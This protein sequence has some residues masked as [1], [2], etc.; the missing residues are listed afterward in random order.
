[1]IILPL[2]RLWPRVSLSALQPAPRS[3]PSRPL[4]SLSLPVPSVPHLINTEWTIPRLLAPGLRTGRLR[5]R[6][7]HQ[8][9]EW[10]S[11]FIS[12]VVS[13]RFDLTMHFFV[14]IFS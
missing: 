8:Q 2:L 11:Y 9:R 7:A 1:M 3:D 6:F 12:S 5:P 4:L 10:G 14:I 13:M